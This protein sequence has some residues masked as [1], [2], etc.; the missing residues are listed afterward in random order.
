[1]IDE[2]R[3]DE[4]VSAWEITD[5]SLTTSD[6]NNITAR[7]MGDLIGT[8]SRDRFPGYFFWLFRE[9]DPFEICFSSI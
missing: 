1:M 3:Q 6:D 4:S 9:H 7:S 2:P 8:P 5:Q